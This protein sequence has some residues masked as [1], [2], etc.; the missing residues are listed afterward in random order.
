MKLRSASVACAAAVLLTAPGV[1]SAIQGESRGGDDQLV[2][3]FQNLSRSTAWQQVDSLRL[4]FDTFHPQGMEVVGDRIYLSSVE[5]LQRPVKYPAPRG[6][7]D[8]SPGK[9][10]GH[11]FVLDRTGRLLQDIELGEGDM[12]HPGGLDFDGDDIWV[13]VGEYRPDSRSIVYRVDAATLEAEKAFVVDDH[14]G[15]VVAD[16][17][18]GRLVGQSW[19]SRRFYEWT[20]TGRQKDRWL[21]DSH[22]VDYQDCEYVAR[23][24]A[25]CS[26]VS[27]L[28]GQ[29]G[30]ATGYELGGLAL[31]DLQSHRILH[32]VP[33]QLWS[34]A[35]HVVTRNPTDVEVDGDRVTLFAAP[36]DFGEGND[37]ELLT[38]Q[39]EVTPLR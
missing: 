36:D 20:A 17:S 3:T 18:T 2:Q 26:G 14:V 34:S 5:I 25:L 6:G 24:K 11:L 16:R 19:G 32:E 28:P 12:Y 9:G 37:T 21:N 23:G 39:A 27:E 38:Y 15:G 7:Y 30:S 31:L 22:L 4:E 35:G 29:P 1:A 8:R 33:V 10:V 13:P